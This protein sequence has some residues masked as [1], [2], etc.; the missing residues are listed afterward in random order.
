MNDDLESAEAGLNEGNSSYHK[1]SDHWH[2]VPRCPKLTN[3]AGNVNSLADVI[4][5]HYS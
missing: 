1:V 4:L 2:T 5:C 3:E